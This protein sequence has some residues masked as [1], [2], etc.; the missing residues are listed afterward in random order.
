VVGLL[1][2]HDSQVVIQLMAEKNYKKR[3]KSSTSSSSTSL[4]ARY[5]FKDSA[6]ETSAEY[7]LQSLAQL[8]RDFPFLWK[9]SVK[10]VLT[11]HNGHYFHA[12][13]AL[14]E[15]TGCAPGCPPANPR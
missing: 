12:R 1:G 9:E 3:A 14:E 11:Q 15:L 6:W 8:M 2:E 4:A 10:S 5:N 13:Q 7:Q